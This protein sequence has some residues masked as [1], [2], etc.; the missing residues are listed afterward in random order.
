MA[1]RVGE[2]RDLIDC[3]AIYNGAAVKQKPQTIA[4]LTQMGVD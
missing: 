2:M 4:F 1:C 3:L